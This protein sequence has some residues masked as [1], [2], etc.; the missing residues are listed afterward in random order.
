MRVIPAPFIQTMAGK[1]NNVVFTKGRSGLNARTKVKPSNPQ[2]SAQTT[3]RAYLKEYTSKWRLLTQNQ[4]AAW[5]TFAEGDRKSNKSGDKYLTTGK[6]LYVGYNCENAL[7]GDGIEITTPPIATPPA[8][9]TVMAID[10]DSTGTPKATVTLS[11]VVPTDSQLQIWVTPMK[12]AGV[13]NFKGKTTFIKKVAAGG[14][15][16]PID[17]ITDYTAKYGSLIAGT[18]VAVQGWLN[19]ADS[20]VFFKKFKAGS[21]LAGKVK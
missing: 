8:L 2:S 15:V 12:S 11:G 4:I 18:K 3:V 10:F 6:N 13:S 14:G 5:N 19:N 17:I 9:I 20:P 21:E 1:L 16:T 7:V